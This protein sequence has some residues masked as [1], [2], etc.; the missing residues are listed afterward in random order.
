MSDL[1]LAL[2]ALTTAGTHQD[3]TDSAQL[4]AARCTAAEEA[5]ECQE[6]LTADKLSGNSGNRLKGRYE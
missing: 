3:N 6:F 2:H 5:E 1:D 4:L